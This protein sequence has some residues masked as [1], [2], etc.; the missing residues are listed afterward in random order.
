MLF[1]KTWLPDA[2]LLAGVASLSYGAWMVYA[3]LG[4]VVPG[5]FAILVGLRL[6]Q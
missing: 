4:Y 1:L 3:P 2:L 5:A 6:A